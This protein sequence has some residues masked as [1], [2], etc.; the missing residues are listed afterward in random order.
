MA[1]LTLVRAMVQTKDP[2]A[3]VKAAG[4][5][6][7]RTM[8]RVAAEQRG[9]HAA[10]RGPPRA[11]P[12]PTRFPRV[13]VGPPSAVSG[14]AA[15][16]HDPAPEPLPSPAQPRIEAPAR[17]G[18]PARLPI[19]ADENYRKPNVVQMWDG[20]GRPASGSYREPV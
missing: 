2:A 16:G 18:S 15:R 10:P 17:P 5:V 19:D 3:A 12:T 11:R 14:G 8:G 6:L 1:M 4:M 9:P 7:D 20:P 13:A